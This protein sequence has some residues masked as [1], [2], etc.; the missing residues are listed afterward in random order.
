MEFFRRWTREEDKAFERALVAIPE[1]APNRWLLIAA[2]VPGRSP[3]EVWE[4]YRLLVNDLEMIERGEVETPW[5]WDDADADDDDA[6]ESSDAP[7]T[8]NGR[9]RQTSFGRGR[10]EERRRGIPWT[11][12]EHRLFLDGLA[13]FGRGDWRNISRWAVKTR[14]P[15][16]VASHAQ[17]Y[18]IRQGPNASNKESKRKSIHDITNP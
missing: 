3:G 9:R 8:S 14:T 16:Q 4:R 7:G 2:Q 10:G 1:G 12:E 6:G 13:K 15:T 17:K 11:E 5:Q 18:F